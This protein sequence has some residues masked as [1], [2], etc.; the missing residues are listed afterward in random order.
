VGPGGKPENVQV[1]AGLGMG[2]NEKAI[3]AVKQWR[4]EPGLKSTVG[5]AVEVP[6]KL[7]S[8]GWGLLAAPFNVELG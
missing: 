7:D 5:M 4:F 8:D 3:E 6:F 1:I 2:L